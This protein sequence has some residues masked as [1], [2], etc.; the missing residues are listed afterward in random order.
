M[1]RISQRESPAVTDAG[2]A[3]L[4]VLGVDAKGPHLH[5]SPARGLDRQKLSS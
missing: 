4:A 3:P 2:L 5:S 1:S